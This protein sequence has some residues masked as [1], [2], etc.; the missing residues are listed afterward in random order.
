[1]T[2][3]CAVAPLGCG[4]IAG[5][6]GSDTGQ[7]TLSAA[8]L[9]FSRADTHYEDAANDDFGTAEFVNVGNEPLLIR[10]RVD[11]PTDVDVYDLGPVLPGDRILIEVSADPWLDGAISIFDDQQRTLL[12]NDHRN[13]YLGRKGPFIDV[14]IRRAA[15]S[16]F[17]AMTATPGFTSI[18]D[19]G[20]VTSKTFN[21]A[22]PPFRSDVVLLDFQGGRNVTIGTRP[23]INVP[24]FDASRISKAFSSDTEGMVERIVALVREDFAGYNVAIL[25]TSEGEEY[26]GTTS[27]LFFGTYDPALLGVAEGVDEYNADQRQEAIVFADTFAAFERLNPTV[28]EMSQ[29][30]ANVA[31]HEI[32]H[33]LGL[34]HTNDPAGIMDVTASLSELLEDQAFK[35][36]PIFAAV[37][38]IG[39]EDSIQM[40]LDGVG[41]DAQVVR[42]KSEFTLRKPFSRPDDGDRRPARTSLRLSLCPGHGH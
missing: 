9:A 38:P 35:E 30:I 29:A 36:S 22:I 24:A 18:G 28:E 32:G 19:Y 25:S 37:F 10:G 15:P 8:V 33:L 17:V 31:S 39:L 26:D 16:C 34:I 12:V 20:L 27:R 21:N 40:L 2:A 11:S 23:A 5:Q 13:V 3:W 7:T 41:G 1:V 4:S 6:G 14:V 42:G